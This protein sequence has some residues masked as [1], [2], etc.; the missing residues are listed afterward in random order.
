M[1]PVQFQVQVAPVHGGE[2]VR[3]PDAR[4]AQV[5]AVHHVQHEERTGALRLEAETE[6]LVAYLLEGRWRQRGRRVLVVPVAEE[7][8]VVEV[9]AVAQAHHVMPAHRK[10][11]AQAVT[12]EET[13]SPAEG[14]PRFQDVARAL[15]AAAVV[16]GTLPQLA[17]NVATA[18]Q[19][20]HQFVADGTGVVHRLREEHKAVPVSPVRPH[21]SAVWR[22]AE[23]VRAQAVRSL[24]HDTAPQTAADGRARPPAIHPRSR[25]SS[26]RTRRRCRSY[27]PCGCAGAATGPRY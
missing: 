7:G 1:V 19:G 27:G 12:A 24:R 11:R 16:R 10:A 22:G 14:E 23:G 17:G 20:R 13:R 25:C 8:E 4:A 3:L 18:P 6:G 9:V 2:K 15:R 5:L 21:V 26:P